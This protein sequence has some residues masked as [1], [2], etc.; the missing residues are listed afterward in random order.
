VTLRKLLP[1]L[2]GGAALYFALFGGEHGLFALRTLK[3]QKAR[4][5][6]ALEQV[7][8]EVATLRARADS[9]ERDPVTLETIA[10]ERYGM[11][12]KGERLYRFTDCAPRQGGAAAADSVGCGG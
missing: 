4:E 1:A 10:R 11:I 12:R 9:L 2:L 8:A 3:R 6:A 5:E 7:K